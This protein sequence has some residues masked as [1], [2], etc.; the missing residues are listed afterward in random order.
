[1]EVLRFRVPGGL[2]SRPTTLGA[3][4]SARE[5]HTLSWITARLDTILGAPRMWGSREAVELQILTLL[6]VRRVVCGEDPMGL[7]DQYVEFVR[8]RYPG[9]WNKPL[10]L[11]LAAEPEEEFVRVLQEL[12]SEL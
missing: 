10:Y 9:H 11:I 3:K 2:P 1:M 4:M 12:R 5:A 6:E 7:L 8:K